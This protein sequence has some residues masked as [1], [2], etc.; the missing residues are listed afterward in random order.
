M[1]DS[2]TALTDFVGSHA[3]RKRILMLGS[4]AVAMGEE[5]ARRFAP[6]QVQI[7]QRRSWLTRLLARPLIGSAVS[8][9]S[10]SSERISRG[11]GTFDLIFVA[12]DEPVSRRAVEN[13]RSHLGSGG[14]LILA[15]ST[16]ADPAID[17]IAR[18]DPSI[19]FLIRDGRCFREI[20]R[21]EVPRDQPLVIVTSSTSNRP[22]RLHLGCGPFAIPGWINIDNH[23]YEAVDRLLDLTAGLPF[24]EVESVF[25]E[26]L[27]EHFELRDAVSLLGECRRV[28]KQEGALR[29][30]TPNLDWV[31]MHTYH[32]DLWSSPSEAIRDCLAFNRGF[33]GW[34]HR[35]L[36]NAPMLEQMLRAAGFGDLRRCEYG[37]SE[38]PELA[39]R[40]KHD[41]YPDSPDLPHILIAEARQP[42]S[43]EAELVA[44]P[45]VQDYLR[46]LSA[47]EQGSFRFQDSSSGWV[48]LTGS[49]FDLSA[50]G[51]LKVAIADRLVERL[52]PDQAIELFRACRRS[53]ADDG[54]L[55]ISTRSLD[56]IWRN[57]YRP[58]EWGSPDDAR[59]DCCALNAAMRGEGRRFIWNEATLRGMLQLAGFARVDVRASGQS[60]GIRDVVHGENAAE[61]PSS[62][63]VEATGR[64][65]SPLSEEMVTALEEYRRDLHVT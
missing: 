56:W 51:E 14:T 60:D 57:L 36:Y 37:R 44:M 61:G 7:L 13:L 24:R 58:L 50:R 20:A 19:R 53:L 35:F 12:A 10:G 4:D 21:D 52:D 23:P 49:T 45:E 39:G 8:V 46:T 1:S 42:G 29:L 48:E 26:H 31:W 9:R 64:E 34:G 25:M 6:E 22:V 3:C 40:E 18:V 41:Q 28:L 30:S 55:R 15:R 11:Q 5:I 2:A 32:P 38:D 63:V 27:L 47:T 17:Q 43:P 54:V 65:E 62:L 59:R 33:R 16:P